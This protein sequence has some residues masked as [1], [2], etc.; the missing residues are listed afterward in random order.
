MSE[1]PEV[2]AS[3]TYVPGRSARASPSAANNDARTGASD[4]MQTSASA[5]RA[6]SAGDAAG[7]T[8]ASCNSSS[9]LRV[10]L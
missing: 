7:V 9:R 10:R 4:S 3:M 6:A 2:L 1:G 8:P 5:S